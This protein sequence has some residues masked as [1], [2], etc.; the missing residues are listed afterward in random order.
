MPETQ[1]K[2]L[3]QALR[4][5]RTDREKAGEGDCPE[6]ELYAVAH[7]EIAG[8]K[9]L[10]GAVLGRASEQFEA[11][12]RGLA[13]ERRE[14][15][16]GLRGVALPP[17]Q[18]LKRL[19]AELAEESSARQR[20]DEEIMRSVV[21]TILRIGESL[22]VEHRERGRSEDGLVQTLNQ[23]VRFTQDQL[24]EQRVRRQEAEG[25]MLA[26]LEQAVCRAS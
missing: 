5:S 8:R 22:D 6:Q 14:R 26:R 7:R 1:L 2:M 13:Q 15:E 23:M 19:G 16:E 17:E 25:R 11:L 24:Q 4:R 21:E 18:K 10:E 12:L 9:D 20:V 3:E